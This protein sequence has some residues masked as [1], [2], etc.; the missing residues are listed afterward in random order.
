MTQL[1]RDN[2][3]EELQLRGHGRFPTESLERYLDW[4]LQDVYRQGK[5]DTVQDLESSDPLA[6]G[7]SAIPF[8]DIAASASGI[9][10]IDAV[11]IKNSTG[12]VFTLDEATRERFWG[13]IYP[14][15][16]TDVSL[17]TRQQPSQYY[18]HGEAVFLFPTPDTAYT[19]HI[20]YTGRAD[21]FASGSATS[22]LPERMDTA[23]LAAAEMQCCKRARDSEGFAIAQAALNAL[24]NLEVGNENR[25]FTEEA[26]RIGR[27]MH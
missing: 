18:V 27:Y 23:V 9:H 12:T 10:S 22:G 16:M 6:A 21:S 2:F 8:T 1:T 14:N 25:Q 17:Q 4:A 19:W 13:D 20:H 7:T 15:S 3:V 26:P 24:I 5:F 11:Y